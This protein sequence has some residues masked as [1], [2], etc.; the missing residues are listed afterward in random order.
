LYIKSKPPITSSSPF[1]LNTY[2]LTF[3]TH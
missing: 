2:I 1:N 3:L